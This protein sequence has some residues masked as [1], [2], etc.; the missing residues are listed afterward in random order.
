MTCA[1]IPNR[2]AANFGAEWK[3]TYNR[4]NKQQQQT[5]KNYLTAKVVELERRY[6]LPLVVDGQLVFDN[7]DQQFAAKYGLDQYRARKKP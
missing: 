2:I 6:G 1:Q 7:K 4:A 3:N 5:N